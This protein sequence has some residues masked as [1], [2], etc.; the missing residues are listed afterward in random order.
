MN[1]NYLFFAFKYNGVSTE[2]L[3]PKKMINLSSHECTQ[4]DYSSLNILLS[5]WLE[6]S[7]FF[8]LGVSTIKT[9]VHATE[10]SG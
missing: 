1:S 10:M 9:I 3:S 6:T 8:S 5:L 4:G 7:F 2:Y